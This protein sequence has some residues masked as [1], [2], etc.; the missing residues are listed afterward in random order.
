MT[1][2]GALVAGPS[3]LEPRPLA[4]AGGVIA[5][6]PAGREIRLEGCT[7]LPGIVDLHGDGFERH[8]APRRGL[9]SDLARGL[10]ALD[11]ELAASGITTAVLAQFWSWEGGMRSPDFARRLAA[12][13]EEAR[14]RLLT[15]MVLQLRLE[16]HL[17]DQFGEVADFV[18]RH[19]I[20]YAVYN[21]HLPHAALRKGRTPPR[22]TGQ[23]LKSGRSPEAH[24]ALIRELAARDPEVPGALAELSARLGAMGVRLGSHDDP[25]PAR[26]AQMRALG[27]GIA[28]FPETMEAVRAAKAAGDAVILGAPNV[29]R[30]G[31]HAGKMDA[32][33]AVAEGLCDA[34]VSDYHYPAPSAAAAALAPGGGAG[35]W[36]LVSEGP[37]RV[38]GWSDRGRLAPGLRADLA[39][40][41]PSGDVEATVSAGRIAF[42]RGAV[43]AALFG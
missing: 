16:T 3:G 30:G 37:A 22:L 7:L 2:A 4:I 27:C 26:R 14:P 39:I 29:V 33:A 17:T 38:M 35:A 31:S 10:V 19:R 15:E 21:D 25:D 13:L 6:A 9:V 41:G 1:F 34:L 23:A 5:D 40:L 24:L 36:H 18:E 43:A 12:A 20:G 11:A 28:E 32:R 42:A 8:L